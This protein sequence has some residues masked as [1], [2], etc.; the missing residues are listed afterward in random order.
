MY[1]GL[2]GQMTSKLAPLH[3][4]K[5]PFPPPFFKQFV[6]LYPA[7]LHLETHPP[8]PPF[9]T[10]ILHSDD[11]PPLDDPPPPPDEELPGIRITTSFAFE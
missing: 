4:F 5:H 6:Q 2:S 9:L 3:L 11:E 8:P 7:P 10:Q 1:D